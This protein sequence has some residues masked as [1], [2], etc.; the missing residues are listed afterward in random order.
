MVSDS[1]DQGARNEDTFFSLSLLTQ[2]NEKASINLAG[3]D[4]AKLLEGLAKDPQLRLEDNPSILAEEQ[5]PTD[6]HALLQGK[7]DGSSTDNIITILRWERYHTP[8]LSE[9][10]KAMLT[11]QKNTTAKLFQFTATTSNPWDEV[12]F[13]FWKHKVTNMVLSAIRLALNDDAKT[14][15]QQASIFHG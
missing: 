5:F 9:E 8:H 15:R 2:M 6:H 13:N 10:Q 4:A 7:T 3:K 1:K 11:E 12:Q 14:R